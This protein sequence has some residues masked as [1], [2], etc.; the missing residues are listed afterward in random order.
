MEATPLTAS[1]AFLVTINGIS[2]LE[3]EAE[4]TYRGEITGLQPQPHLPMFF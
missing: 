4:L 1:T 2:G 3:P